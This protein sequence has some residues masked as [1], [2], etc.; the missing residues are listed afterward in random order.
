[1]PSTTSMVVSRP[2]ASSTV[3]TPSLPTLDI[4]SAMMLP[5]VAS[6]LAEMVPIWAISFWSR[7]GLARLASSAIRASTPLSMPRLIAMGLRPAATSLMP[8]WYTAWARM[9]AVVVPSPAASEVLEA[10]SFTSWAPMF[11][12]L[13][14]SSIS[15]ATVTPSLVMTGAPKDFSRATLRPLGPR[16]TLTALASLSTPRASFSRALTSKKISLAH[17]FR[18]PPGW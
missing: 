15:L 6:E 1:M 9:V 11:S 2:L 5:M 14:S 16:V 13:S 10:T 8:S 7:V 12:N 3:M 18:V 17:I 4:A